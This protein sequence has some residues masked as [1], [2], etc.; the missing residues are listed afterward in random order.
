MSD[1][2]QH[3]H[4]L[5][6]P[7]ARIGAGTRIWAFT[8]V[9]PGAVIGRDC[10][11]CDRA[12]IEGKVQV[13]DRVTIKCGVSLWDGVVIEDD[14]FI[15]PSV[16]FT[17]DKRPR[18]RRQPESYLQILVRRGCSLG[19]NSTILPGLTIGSWSMIG[20]GAVVTGDVPAHALM[21]GCP[22]RRTGWVCRC[23]EKLT[24]T[25]LR[26]LVCSCGLRY[27]ILAEDMLREVAEVANDTSSRTRIGAV[28]L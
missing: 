21:V 11:I 3:S 17:N 2:F 16:V 10:N 18:S 25:K 22:A 5:V 20:A 24:L 1:Y 7:G 9:L 15:G 28:G 13:G 27:E 4:A 6:E 14:V 12:F 8:H 23:G 19:A 26:H